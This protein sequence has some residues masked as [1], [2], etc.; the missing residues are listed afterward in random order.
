MAGPQEAH[1]GPVFG[2]YKMML[3]RVAV[4][5]RLVFTEVTKT[6]AATRCRTG[7]EKVNIKQ[8]K[9]KNFH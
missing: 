2:A 9:Q 4:L 7:T 8:T 5:E 1:F 6:D 3:S